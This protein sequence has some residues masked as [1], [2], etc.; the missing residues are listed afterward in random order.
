MPFLSQTTQYALYAL[1]YLGKLP[2]GEFAFAKN[3]AAAE[4]VPANYLAKVL[5]RLAR[6]GMLD[7]VRGPGGGFRLRVSLDD[8]TLD[9]VRSLFEGAWNERLCILGRRQCSEA[10][11]C[12]AHPQFK[13]VAA[14][15]HDYLTQTT[16]AQLMAQGGVGSLPAE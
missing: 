6:E 5:Q 13:T 14:V 9:Q 2:E 8:V 7:S 16:V 4:D 3:I 12:G 15:M 10:N 1:T 11:P